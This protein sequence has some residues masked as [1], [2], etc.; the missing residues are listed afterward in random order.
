MFKAF[1]RL[2]FCPVVRRVEQPVA[3]LEVEVGVHRLSA[4]DGNAR[5]RVDLRQTVKWVAG[6]RPISGCSIR[7][8]KHE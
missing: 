3:L 8:F 2:I 5:H 4:A 1:A 7:Y 6:R